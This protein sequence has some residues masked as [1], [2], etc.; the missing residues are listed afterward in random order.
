[1]LF[2]VKMKMKGVEKNTKKPGIY[3][4][5]DTNK[6]VQQPLLLPHTFSTASDCSCGNLPTT[7]YILQECHFGPH[8]SDSNLKEANLKNYPPHPSYAAESIFL[9]A[10]CFLMMLP[11]IYSLSYFKLFFDASVEMYLLTFS[12]KKIVLRIFY[13]CKNLKSLQ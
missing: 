13:H 2:L 9:V 6:I 3:S 11:V 5:D 10:W 4:C 12:K 7:E 1:M 8:R